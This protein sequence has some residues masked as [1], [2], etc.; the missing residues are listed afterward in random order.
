V[1]QW[2]LTFNNLIRRTDFVPFLGK[3]LAILEGAYGQPVDIEF[4]A[5]SMGGNPCASTFFNAAR[6]FCRLSDR[7]FRAD[8]S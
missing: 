6:C 3:M 4:T 1:D 2:V 8:L 7:C 5:L